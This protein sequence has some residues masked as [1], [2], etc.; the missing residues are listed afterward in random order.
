MTTHRIAF[1]AALVVG[2]LALTSVGV[3]AVGSD[4]PASP[5]DNESTMGDR[6]GA[7][8]QASSASAD[9]SIDRG[10]FDQSL[11]ESADKEALVRERIEALEAEYEEARNLSA[12]IDTNSSVPAPA[13]RATLVRLTMQLDS[14]NASIEETGDHA[15]AVGVDTERLE[16]LRANASE[17]TGPEVAEIATGMAGVNPPGLQDAHPGNGNQ[18]AG[19][20]NSEAGGPGNSSDPPGEGGSGNGNSGAGAPGNG[21]ESPGDGGQG[22]GNGGAGA[23]GNGNDSPGNADPGSADSTAASTAG[24]NWV[25]DAGSIRSLVV[26]VASSFW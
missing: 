26:P 8:M 22:N 23:P 10:M 15:R 7:F 19:N 11:N 21:T 17:L 6:I 12:S 1:V 18:G 5:D 9:G 14:L 13:R 16:T 20:G 3:V 24:V 25:A 2:A 4:A